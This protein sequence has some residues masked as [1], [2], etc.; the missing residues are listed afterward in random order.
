MLQNWTAHRLSRA[1]FNVLLMIHDL[2]NERTVNWTHW[3]TKEAT[4]EG[5]QLILLHTTAK[6]HRD[7]ES[8]QDV[9]SETDRP[10]AKTATLKSHELWLDSQNCWRSREAKKL[11][12]VTI[13]SRL[14]KRKVWRPLLSFENQWSFWGT[15]ECLLFRGFWTLLTCSS[16]HWVK[17][18]IGISCSGVKP[19]TPDSFTFCSILT[20][21][22]KPDE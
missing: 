18:M 11:C 19:K 9:T 13:G 5:T 8:T 21:G 22:A 16:V 15:Q 17:S 2:N 4:A 1:L 14:F 7:N 12:A 6:E 20:S 10:L 3:R